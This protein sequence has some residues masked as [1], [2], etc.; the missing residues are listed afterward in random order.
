MGKQAVFNQD[1]NVIDYT[2]GAD[3]SVGDVVPMTNFCGVALTGIANG[4]TGAVKVDGI[5]AIP[6]D[7]GAAWNVGDKI[8]WNDTTNVGTKTATDNTPLGY[9]VAAKLSAGT[10][11]KV[12]LVK[13]A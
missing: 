4:A 8:Y 10:S 9:A 5:Y 3:I 1:G 7:T 2:A 6:T 12:L 11:C 13:G